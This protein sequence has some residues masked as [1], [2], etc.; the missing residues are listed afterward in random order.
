MDPHERVNQISK[1]AAQD[2]VELQMHEVLREMLARVYVRDELRVQ[3]VV[4]RVDASLSRGA[5]WSK[6]GNQRRQ[7]AV[8]GGGS[9]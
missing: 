2:A 9:G 4:Q 1:L 7:A 6:R 3:G 8:D 5:R